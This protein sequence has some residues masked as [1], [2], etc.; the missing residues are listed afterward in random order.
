M[1]RM[2]NPLF[3]AYRLACTHPGCTGLQSIEQAMSAGWQLGDVIP[4]DASHPDVARCPRC[5]RH[6]MKVVAAPEPLQ[7]D[8]PKGFTEIPRE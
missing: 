2:V 6:N 7:P 8:P 3:V 4:Y 5:K 1:P